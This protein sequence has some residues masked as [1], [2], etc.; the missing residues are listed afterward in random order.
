MNYPLISE[1]VDA[2]KLAEDNFCQ[3]SNLR[4]VLDAHGE[5][6]MSS[7]NFAVVFK[8]V[9][10]NGNFHALKCF[11][12]EQQ[13][14]ATAYRQISDTLATID[15]PYLTATQYYEKELYVDTS[16]SDETEFP[17]LLM[18]WV[19]GQTLDKYLRANLGNKNAL[20]RLAFR[21][22]QLAKWLLPQ[23]FAHGDLKPD[24]I[25]VRGDG[26]LVLIDYDGMYVP[27]MLGQKSRE[28]G[29]PDFRHPFR[30]EDDFDE[31]ID[32]FPAMSILFSLLVLAHNPEL[33]ERYGASDRLLFSET[34]Y[35]SIS[36]CALLKEHFP[37]EDTV[38]NRI[39]GLFLIALSDVKLPQPLSAGLLNLPEPAAL[40]PAAIVS[41]EATKEDWKNAVEDEHGVKYSADWK[42]LLECC[43]KRKDTHYTIHEGTEI[44]C[45]WAFSRCKNLQQITLPNSLT[46]IGD[47][48]FYI[49]ESLQEITLPDSVTN[50]G[51]QAFSECTS[52]QKIN[53]PDSLNSIGASAFSGC[54][55]LQ[56]ITL[57]DSLNS[58]GDYAFCHCESLQEINLPDSLN[59]IGASAFSGCENLQLITFPDSLN[60][61]GAHAFYHCESLQQ[62]TLP[63]SVSNIGDEAFSCCK[64]LQKI[65]LPDSLNSIGDEAFSYCKNLQQ[66]TLPDSL[67]SIGSMVFSGCD[68]ISIRSDSSRFIVKQ[69]LL[70]DRRE[71]R[72]ISYIGKDEIITIP[73]TITSIGDFAF[74]DCE[75]L[76]Q[77]TLPDL[78]TSIGAHAFYHCESL[79]QI[80]LPDSVTTIG[81]DAFSGCKNLQQI[82]LPDSLTSI[83]NSAFSSC[84]NLQQI[85][86]PDSLTSIGDEVFS[87]CKNLQQITLPDSITSIG[88]SAFSSC[89]NLQQITLP[90]SITSIGDYAFSDCENLRQITLPNSLTSIG[91]YAFYICESLQ[92]ITL[93]DSVTNIGDEAFS[94][95][96]SLQKVNLPKSLTSIGSKVF[97][98]CDHISLKSDSSRFIVE[99]DLLIDMREHRLISCVGK[100][101]IITIPDSVTS[102]GDYAFYFC[103][104][105]QKINL[106]NSLTRIGTCA[107]CCC[108]S[109]QEITLPDSITDIGDGAFVSC[110]NLK[111]IAFPNTSTNI[112]DEVLASCE[113]LK[114]I[115]L[116][117]PHISIE[118]NSFG[119]VCGGGAEGYWIS[120]VS[121]EKI[122]IPSGTR[123]KFK[124]LLPI[125]LHDKLVEYPDATNFE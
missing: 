119:A 36:E 125:K 92:E 57:L 10:D 52:L 72:L 46:S 79:Q 120:Y 8:M 28:M 81:D 31:R 16:Q 90:D 35:R 64:S 115:K 108:F 106:P 56:Q 14:R 83:G 86:L 113:S 34:D 7:G 30:T 51:D 48:A 70:I 40:K 38:L 116:P 102:I 1:Y 5:P 95:C 110:Y 118:E 68:N 111:N 24:N 19:E 124:K 101:K 55:N 85:T 29:S 109:L 11:I 122:F 20:Q 60:S 67:T 25:L 89:R 41:T 45:D 63:D 100:N 82:T 21:F 71:H 33:L 77:I 15:S 74:S 117:N 49:C 105:L 2:I 37:T 62:I 66:I 96:T 97:L 4:P 43:D 13:G 22:C 39:G 12:R 65:N 18:D 32:D 123:E 94:K 3:L 87:Y 73:D 53:L 17:V 103:K 78:L 58:I 93:P 42:K 61:I 27:A 59:S 47:Y 91:D 6:V 50:I 112:G 75:D 107:F 80:T 44:I 23:S 98:E 9:D 69:D 104:S 54:E 121:A 84:K 76:Q 114:T 88:N 99:Q 26:S